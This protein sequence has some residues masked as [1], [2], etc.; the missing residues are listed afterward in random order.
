MG[1]YITTEIR[2]TITTVKKN[3][4]RIL[5]VSDQRA[6]HVW[7][8]KGKTMTFK[9]E[10]LK[11]FKTPENSGAFGSIH[12]LEK[13]DFGNADGQLKSCFVVKV[14]SRKWEAGSTMDIKERCFGY[15]EL[16]TLQYKRLLKASDPMHSN[17]YVNHFY[18]SSEDKPS[19][20]DLYIVLRKCEVIIS[21]LI[22]KVHHLKSGHT[23]DKNFVASEKFPTSVLVSICQLFYDGIGFIHNDVKPQNMGFTIRNGEP[24]IEYIDYGSLNMNQDT[25][26]DDAEYSDFPSTMLFWSPNKVPSLDIDVSEFIESDDM[27]MQDIIIDENSLVK[28]MKTTCKKSKPNFRIGVGDNFWAQCQTV[29]EC[30]LGQN[31]VLFYAFGRQDIAKDNKTRLT[32]IFRTIKETN[33]FEKFI[34]SDI[35]QNM[36]KDDPKFAPVLT[37]LK[38]GFDQDPAKRENAARRSSEL[39]KIFYAKPNPPNLKQDLAKYYP[40]FE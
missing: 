13:Y 11:K 40:I 31:P 18:F 25:E 35:Y 36:Y 17:L 16:V 28:T 30:I 15:N 1:F 33:F 39:G 19:K 10:D 27:S 2:T 14:Q 22:E 23:Y 4:N 7:L 26:R 32:A 24:H 9:L 37:F 12:F 6:S 29:Y 34:E 20:F 21:N 3:K 8:K 5:R 38:L